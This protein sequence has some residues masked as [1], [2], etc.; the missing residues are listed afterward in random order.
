MLGRPTRGWALQDWQ[1]VKSRLYSPNRNGA[2]V[3]MT[4]AAKNRNLPMTRSAQLA[5]PAVICLLPIVALLRPQGL[6]PLG[7]AAALALLT[8]RAVRA[9]F[10][11]HLRGP[12]TKTLCCLLIW[13][14][15]SAAWAPHPFGSLL[16]VL[17]VAGVMIAGTLLVAGF[18]CLDDETRRR[19]IVALV[20][21]GPALLLMAGAELLSD[22]VLARAVRGWPSDSTFNP[23]IYDRTAAIVAIISWPIAFTLWRR[24][25]PRA[26]IVFLVLVFVL[27]LQLEMAAARGAF[28]IAGAVFTVAYWKPR[29]S[30]LVMTAAV[31]AAILIVPPAMIATG[32]DRELPAVA[33][34]LPQHSPSAKHRLFIYQFVLGKIAERPLAG[35]G[36]DSSR[37]ISGGK[38]EAFAGAPLLPL[39]PHNAILQIWLELGAVGAVIAAVLVILVLRRL[40]AFSANPGPA[41]MASATFAAFTT[42][43]LLSFGIWQNWWLMTAWFAAVLVGFAANVRPL[44]DQFE[45]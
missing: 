37:A 4:A 20:I 24:I 43:A 7:V 34:D 18:E 22:G 25:R 21:A 39:H 8:D 38:T 19:A 30:L 45:A 26:A 11:D 36:F 44:Q 32:A 5:F 2:K 29:A 16:L 23:V 9:R 17:Q 12:L 3:P 31:L 14:A 42:I 6:V 41:A 40:L 27:L 35:F 10:R 13:A 15:L 28:V 1:E 33:A